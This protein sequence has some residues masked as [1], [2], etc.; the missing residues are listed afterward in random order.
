MPCS[1]IK[2]ALRT[3]IAACCLFWLMADGL[4]GQGGPPCSVAT[5]AILIQKVV[6][7]S[8]RIPLRDALVTAS[9]RVGNARDEASARTDSTGTAVLCV[10]AQRVIT[11][12]VSY[13][14]HSAL[15][16]TTVAALGTTTTHTAFIDLPGS[17]FRGRVVDHLTGDGV[18]QVSIRI[19]NTPFTTVTQP[20]GRF[21]FER[22]PFGLYNVMVEH[23]AYSV[24][25]IALNVRHE[26]L[27]ALVRL[28]PA[29]IAVQPI[30]VTAFSRRLENVGFY[31]REKRG[32]G[33]FIN[34][35]QIDAMNVQAASDLLRRV[36]SLRLVPQSRRS[37]QRNATV[38]VR[39][40]CRFAFIVDGSRTLSDFEMDYVA[41]PALEGV[42]IY[43]GLAEVPAAFRAHATTAGGVS[44]CGV[45][46][47]WTRNSR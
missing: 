16:Q 8:T 41:A 28:T 37:S 18:A 10:P 5:D 26:D 1:H 12:R 35:R 6:D 31:E 2:P 25:S 9:W 43:N 38:G 11:M 29:V 34:R 33:T 40:N 17:L 45:I 23:I 19:A 7:K 36:P 13:A 47:I 39:G 21:V 4:A 30:V 14:D 15:P 42:E 44:V 24:T 46:A 27:D 3:A 32:V 22:L 20:D